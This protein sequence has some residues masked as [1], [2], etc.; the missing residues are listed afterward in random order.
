LRSESEIAQTGIEF[1]DRFGP[2]PQGV[3]DLLFQMKVKLRGEAAGIEAIS[4]NNNQVLLSYPPLPNGVKDRGL[5]EID[6]IVRAGKNGYWV[7]IADL[8]KDEWKARLLSILQ[9]I[10]QQGSQPD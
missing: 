9:K 1:A 5:P 10:I 4:I 6:P 8:S 7:N 3:L 2:I